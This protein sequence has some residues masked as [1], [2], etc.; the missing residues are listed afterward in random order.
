[1]KDKKILKGKINSIKN[2]NMENEN[3]GKNNS[4]GNMSQTKMFISGIVA[5]VLVLCTI[6]FFILLGILLKGGSLDLT[7]SAVKSADNAGDTLAVDPSQ[8]AVADIPAVDEKNDN[9]LGSKNAKITLIEYSDF[10]C[11]YCASFYSTVAQARQEYD[12]QLRVVF[13][14]FPLT[15]IHP[16]AQPAAEAAECAGEQ[17]KFWEFH[18]GIFE[19]QSSLSAD[20]YK[21]LAADLKLNVNK[22]NDCVSSGKYKSKIQQQQAAGSAAGVGGT[23]Y[24]V[25]M[26]SDGNSVPISGAQPFDNLKAAIDSLLQ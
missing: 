20:Y 2:K 7:G 12:D 22:F 9:I 24:S 16:Q 10:Q 8:E 4:L 5:G 18:N 21:V 1:M 11:P 15:S 3:F 13:R 26:D 17:G 19:N 25:L 6:G 23:P 14:H